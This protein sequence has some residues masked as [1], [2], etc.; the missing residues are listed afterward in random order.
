MSRS[1]LPEYPA[2]LR[3]GDQLASFL[4]V[5]DPR[6]SFSPAAVGD[7]QAP[8]PVKTSS[9]TVYCEA[10]R[11]SASEVDTGFLWSVEEAERES[12]AGREDRPAT[13]GVHE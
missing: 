13:V 10:R 6:Q 2:S 11:A 3:P 7:F 12:P 4:F 1:N 8:K 5:K 9:F